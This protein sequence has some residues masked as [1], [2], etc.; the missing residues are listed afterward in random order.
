[1]SLTSSQLRRR[2]LDFFA[3]RG[4]AEVASSALVPR[5]DPTLLFT[6]AG[7]V[8]FKD[9]FTGREERPYRRATTSQKCVRAGGKHNDLENVGRTARHHTF[10][11]MLGN[12]SFGDYFKRDAIAYAWELVTGVFGIAVDRLAVTVFQGAEGVPADDEAFGLWKEIAGLPESR[13]HRL[14]MKD[15]F[16]QMGETGPC[17]PCSEIH[18]FQGGDIPCAEEKAG[19]K[20]LGVECDCDRWLEIWNLVFMQ[21]ERSADE[22]GKI[23]MRPLPKP[24][25]DTGMGLERLTAVVQGK[26]SNYETDL[27]LP[28]IERVAKLSGKRFVPDDFEGE[29]VSLRAIA[30]HA[31][32]TTFLMADGV[33]PEKTGREYVLR[34]I[35]RRAIYHGWQ[36]GIAEPFLHEITDV[37]IGLMKEAYPEVAERRETI[38]RNTLEEEKR[39][40]ETI[41]RGIELIDKNTEWVQGAGGQKVMPGKVAFKLYDTFGFPI[42]LTHLIGQ[43]RGFTVDE[44]GYEAAMDEQRGRSTFQGSGEKASEAVFQALSQ[45]IPPA[46]SLYHDGRGTSGQGKVVALV[47]LDSGREVESAPAGTTVGVVLDQTPF[48]AE[49]GGQIGD[50]GVLRFPG[51]LMKVE[52]TVRPA[53]ELVLHRGTVV[54]GSVKLGETAQ[55]E[56]DAVR[57]E[58]IRRNHSATHLLHFALREVLGAHV[59]QKGSLVAPDRLRFDFSHFAPLSAEER[60]QVEELVNQLVLENADAQ[61]EVLPLSQAKQKGAIAFFGEKYGDTVRVVQ[62]GPRSLEFCGGT[63][64][65]RT[66]DI[67]LFKITAE[68]GIAQGV[69]RIEA[70]SGEGAFQHVRR[71]EDELERVASALKHTGSRLDGELG[72]RAEK[73][74]RAEKE[75]LQKIAELQ[76]KLATGQKG[77]DPLA[78]VREVAG[79]KVLA[80]Q[81]EVGDKKVLRDVGDK[82]RD[83]LQ[84]GVLVLGGVVEGKVTLLAMVTKDLTGKVHAGKLIG[85]IAGEV[86]GRG[87]GRPDMAEAGGDKPDGLPRALERAVA[88]VER[89]AQ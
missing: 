5:N 33:F 52:D 57:R 77:N 38:N 71:L 28:L 23:S 16:W 88:I 14:G 13:I 19:G 29:S 76:Q 87:G 42:D 8:Q 34:R 49:Q 9:V 60:R 63:H 61:T 86:G 74:A 26:R 53:G 22:S 48:Y 55:A 58:A 45:R 50:T 54:E 12:F 44:K 43:K 39:F 89:S 78:Q 62:M 85:E 41:A 79:I 25:I 64:V 72:A 59:A 51:G 83:K 4:H 32:A 80:T 56:V 40:R 24:S 2:F 65:R 73:Y 68:Q 3:E 30:D 70:V 84:S 81:L 67:G 69:R 15:N 66:G 17:G 10:F 21:F 6:N 35:M 27:W 11:E 37:C 18:F 82:L 1:M 46:R 31:R 36:L 20:C 47:H 75:L 7:M